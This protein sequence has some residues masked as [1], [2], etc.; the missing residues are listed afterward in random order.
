M[1]LNLKFSLLSSLTSVD[2]LFKEWMKE[3]LILKLM[4]GFLKIVFE[5]GKPM[6]DV[7]Q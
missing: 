2:K 6:S 3:P 1:F 5:L 4:I 7:G